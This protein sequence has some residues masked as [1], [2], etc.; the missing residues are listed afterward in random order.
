MFVFYKLYQY[1]FPLLLL[2]LWLIV[3]VLLSNYSVSGESNAASNQISNQVY[4]RKEI[5]SNFKSLNIS[6]PQKQSMNEDAR[7]IVLENG[8]TVIT[9]E[10]HTAPVVTVQ[11]WYRI[12]S[13]NEEQGVNGIAHQLEHM[14]FKGTARRPIQFGRLFSTLGS[15]S[16]AF[17]SYDQ[18]AYYNTVERTKLNALLELEADRMHNSLIDAPALA[19]EKRVVISEL[20]GYE[21]NP[22]Y[23]LSHAVMHA[24]FPDH[25][26]GLSV[27][28]KKSDVEKFTV[29][30]V[31]EY[32]NKFYRPDNAVLVIVGDFQ[33]ESTIADVKRIFNNSAEKKVLS[34]EYKNG[35]RRDAINR[36]STGPIILKEPGAASILQSVYPLP[37]I[38]HPDAPALDVMDYILSDGRNS[39]LYQA[40]V[41]SG[42]A[43]DVDASVASLKDFG[44]YEITIL[45]TPKQDLKK[46]D[47]IVTKVIS[48]FTEEG[49]DESEL[50]RAKAQFESSVILGNRDITSQAMQLGNDEVVTGNHLFMDNYLDA[51]RKVTAQDVQRVAKHYLNIESRTF[52][53]FLPTQAP[54]IAKNSS[55]NNKINSNQ[56]HESFTSSSGGVLDKA[57]VLKYL[58][59]FEAPSETLQSV[60]ELVMFPNGLRVLMLPDK[61]TPTV[62][63]SGYIKAGS[64]F[65]CDNKAGLS[66]LVADNLLSG[67]KT[68]DVLQLAKALEERGASLDF[69]P[70]REGVRIEGD[71][72]A[73]DLSVLLHTLA[74][75]IKNP[76]F[77]NRELEL[78]RKHAL[79]ALEQDLDDPSEVARRTFVQSIYPKP[80]PLHKFPTKQSL[81]RIT[82]KDV[83]DF[84]AKYYRPDA[85]VLALVGD[86]NPAEV[87][88]RLKGELGDWSVDGKAETLLYPSVSMP[89]NVIRVNSVLPGKAQTI[90]YMGNTAINRNDSRYYSALVLN[91]ILGGDTLSSRLGAELRDRQGLTYGIFSNF[92]AGKNSGTFLIEMQTSP[93]DTAKAIASTRQLLQDIHKLGV[94]EQEV[95]TAKRTVVSNYIVSLANPEELVHQILMNQVYGLDVEELRN[96]TEKINQVG[97]SQ[98][99]QAARELL[100]PDKIVVVTAGPAVATQGIQPN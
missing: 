27:G 4:T 3:V 89:D 30:K 66:E 63:L 32:Y 35:I 84:K 46:I 86:F 100:N 49:V 16:N 87:K 64:E 28:G 21:N 9:K 31:Q 42:I 24:A 81:R 17:T 62:T 22:E 77:P 36:V 74:D 13:R 39:R 18:T 78:S 93:Q 58:P 40:L 23:R 53:Y 68:K 14:M 75:V 83:I 76:T 88:S 70:S 80:H 43:T 67:T 85:M 73:E 54:V 55:S 44:W 65:D 15:D 34:A 95:E 38:K 69:N 52:G 79:S 1:R 82:R 56:T 12:G 59:Q 11:V 20:Q 25:P 50:K 6:N 41:D 10:V 91:Q 48:K 5:T 2:S 19:S 8:L 61:S 90:T 94:T 26:Y 96:F 71:S 7:K 29:E 92:L 57:D 33:T 99:N 60:P 37:D 47:S 72:L 51:V 98:V 97:L 45:A